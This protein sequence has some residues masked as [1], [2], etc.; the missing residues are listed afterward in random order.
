MTDVNEAFCKELAELKNACSVLEYSYQKCLK[1]G[2]PPGLSNEELESFEALTSRFARLSDIIIQKIFRY[3]D[4]LDLEKQGTVRDRINRAE[5]RG[6]I[7]SANDFI[8]I[9][10]L[11][12]EISHEYQSETIYAIFEK[13][14]E[15]TPVLL[16]SVPEILDYSRKYTD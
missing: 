9:R 13:V 6:I 12:N 3:I 16:K 8:E 4:T 10:M 15:L 7:D 2:V 14:K 1:I 5:K 11:R